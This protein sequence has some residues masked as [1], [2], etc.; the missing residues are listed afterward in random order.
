MEKFKGILWLDACATT[1]NGEESYELLLACPRDL[2]GSVVSSQVATAQELL[3]Y[4][5]TTSDNARSSSQSTR[6]M[7]SRGRGSGAGCGKG[8]YTCTFGEDES[9]LQSTYCH[10]IIRQCEILNSAVLK[11]CLPSIYCFKLLGTANTERDNYGII[12][13][14]QVAA[15]LSFFSNSFHCDE[16]DVDMSG[17]M[18]EAILGSQ[19]Y[20]EVRTSNKVT[21]ETDSYS[22]LRFGETAEQKELTALDIFLKG[23]FQPCPL[24]IGALLTY[25]QK[26][27]ENNALLPRRYVHLPALGITLH[28]HNNSDSLFTLR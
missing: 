17:S 28:L 7:M 21:Y 13:F 3:S 14:Q 11:I 24:G 19:W 27:G 5:R 16:S 23:H 10:Q 22:K 1:D 15:S 2:L 25:V 26:K 18:F 20:H 4:F 6:I 12:N 9:S 8:Q